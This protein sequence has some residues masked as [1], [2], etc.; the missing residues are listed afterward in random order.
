MNWNL[1]PCF[2]CLR[3]RE[4]QLLTTLEFFCELFFIYSLQKRKYV[5]FVFLFFTKVVVYKEEICLLEETV[6]FCPLCYEK[7]NKNANAHNFLTKKRI[8]RDEFKVSKST[9]IL[10]I[11]LNKFYEMGFHINYKL[12]NLTP[13]NATS[14]IRP[15]D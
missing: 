5:N 4:D 14:Y 8:D 6:P 2:I 3:R 10:Q 13:P 12:H 15:C 9:L 11:I 7:G 1:V